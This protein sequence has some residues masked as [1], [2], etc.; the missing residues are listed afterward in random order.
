MSKSISNE[1][2][3]KYQNDLSQRKEAKAL[4]RAVSHNGINKTAAN[5]SSEDR[6]SVV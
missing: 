1:N 2:I 3:Q 5:F 4:Q 6:K